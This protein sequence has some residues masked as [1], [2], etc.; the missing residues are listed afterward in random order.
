VRLP[1]GYAVLRVLEKKP[2][3]PAA[4]VKE[5]DSLT[6]SLVE[7]RREMLFRAYLQEARKRFPV[8]KR[9]EVLRRAVA[10]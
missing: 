2:F 4:F 5:K 7:E 6:A 1:R 10:S 3:D 8:E 9:P